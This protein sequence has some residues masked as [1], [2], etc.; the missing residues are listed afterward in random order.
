MMHTQGV[1]VCNGAA[2]VTRRVVDLSAENSSFLAK[3]PGLALGS[4]DMECIGWELRSVGRQQVI[5]A[6]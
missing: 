5:E 4:D 2:R 6:Y 3:N 1:F